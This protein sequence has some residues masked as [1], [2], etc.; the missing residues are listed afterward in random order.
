VILSKFRSRY[1]L[2]SHRNRNFLGCHQGRL[3]E[4]TVASSRLRAVLKIRRILSLVPYSILSLLI[5]WKVVWRNKVGCTIMTARGA[6]GVQGPGR[7]R[8]S[9][10]AQPHQE[11][12]HGWGAMHAARR[13]YKDLYTPRASRPHGYLYAGRA[14]RVAVTP[15]CAARRRRWRRASSRRARRASRK[16]WSF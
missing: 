4:R 10:A 14:A 8:R 15:R 16:T 13:G 1:H 6:A 11:G 9:E 5:V 3:S 7:G 2:R 12:A